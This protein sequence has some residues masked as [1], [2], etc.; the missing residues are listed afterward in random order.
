RL[1]AVMLL[2][3]GCG[4][5]HDG[6]TLVVELLAGAEVNLDQVRVELLQ[7]DGK[8][9]AKTVA[10]PRSSDQIVK[11]QVEMMVELAVPSQTSGAWGDIPGRSYESYRATTGVDPHALVDAAAGHAIGYVRA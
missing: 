5:Q 7:L 9:Q 8:G 1:A 6:S 10:W 3:V 11:T 2:A 4:G